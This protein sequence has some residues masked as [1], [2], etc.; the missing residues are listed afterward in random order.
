MPTSTGERPDLPEY[1]TWEELEQL[2]DEIAGEIELW[3]GRVVWMRRAPAE[4]QDYS[5][6]LRNGLRRCAREEMANKPDRRWRAST[7][8][9]VF[10]GTTG[11]SDFVTPDF[12]VYPCLKQEYQDIRASDVLIAGEVLSPS[13]TERDVEAKKAR[14]AG[15]GIPWYWEVILGR[16][17]RRISSIRAY[18]LETGHGRLPNGVAPLRPVNYIIAGEWTPA[19]SD[20]ISFDSPFPLH[21]PWSEL[22]F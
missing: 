14:Y 17:P 5:V 6:E 1:M 13:N 21:I 22:E 11:K 20:G 7:E 12:L 10:F 18:G 3:E 8:T 19:G 4:H 2:P 16:N 9:N 15:A